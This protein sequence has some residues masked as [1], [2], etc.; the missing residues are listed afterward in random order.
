VNANQCAQLGYY[1][2]KKKKKK[3]RRRRKNSW[4]DRHY[5]ASALDP[6]ELAESESF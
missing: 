1:L 6:K 3:K 4:T 5:Y 2:K